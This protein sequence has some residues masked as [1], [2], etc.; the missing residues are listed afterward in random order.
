MLGLQQFVHIDIRSNRGQVVA[1]ST[2]HKHGRRYSWVTGDP[3]RAPGQ[4]ENTGELPEVLPGFSWPSKAL[5]RPKKPATFFEFE[6]EQRKYLPVDTKTSTCRTQDF[7]ISRTTYRNRMRLYALENSI[8]PS[9]FHSTLDH[10]RLHARVS[11]GTSDCISEGRE[12]KTGGSHISHGTKKAPHTL[13]ACS[14]RDN[15]VYAEQGHEPVSIASRRR[16]VGL[17]CYDREYM[18]ARDGPGRMLN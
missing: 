8:T 2:Q 5:S 13:P 6:E 14:S 15:I 18:H 10:Q 11:P 12:I 16:M 3:Y 7:Q 4:L 17:P 1:P 9:T